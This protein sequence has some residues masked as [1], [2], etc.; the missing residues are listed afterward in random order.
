VE[1]PAGS[2]C[3][4]ERAAG[5]DGKK[6]QAARFERAKDRFLEENSR[7]GFQEDGLRLRSTE[8]TQITT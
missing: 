5:Q 2:A 8:L 4:V 6:A 7:A 1:N 3:Q